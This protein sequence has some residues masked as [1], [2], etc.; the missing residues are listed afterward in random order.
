MS[1]QATAE[2]AFFRVLPPEV[3][4]AI[5]TAAF[6]G[7]TIHIQPC[8]EAELEAHAQESRPRG[9]IGAARHWI[10]GLVADRTWGK[11]GAARPDQRPVR[12]CGRTCAGV[13]WEPSWES[14]VRD[15]CL[16]LWNRSALGSR[17][18][19]ASEPEFAV[20]ATGW[21]LTCRRA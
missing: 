11:M 2:S 5:Y 12:W 21:L 3:R 17:C 9:H 16:D 15:G 8:Q 10:R 19:C 13:P 18:S 7:G 1:D 6:G 4:I 14:P 20:G